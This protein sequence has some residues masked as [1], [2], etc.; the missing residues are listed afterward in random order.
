MAYTS[1][2]MA[3]I[4]AESPTSRLARSLASGVILL[5][6]VEIAG[7]I[8]SVQDDISG[9]LL[10][11][12]FGTARGELHV[13]VLY[14]VSSPTRDD[15]KKKLNRTVCAVLEERLRELR[16]KAVLA[17]ADLN[18]VASG[19]DRAGKEMLTYDMDPAAVWKVFEAGGLQDLHRLRHPNASDLS[20]VRRSQGVSRIDGIWASME[21]IR[22]DPGGVPSIRS[23]ITK[24]VLPLSVD[25]RTIQA[26]IGLP[27]DFKWQAVAGAGV[28]AVT[29]AP[30]PAHAPMTDKDVSEYR[31]RL[32][33]HDETI[34]EADV[35]LKRA[36]GEWPEIST[37]IERLGLQDYITAADVSVALARAHSAEGDAE[38]ASAEKAAKTLLRLADPYDGTVSPARKHRTGQLYSSTWCSQSCESVCRS[39]G[40]VRKTTQQPRTWHFDS[41]GSRYAT[42]VAAVSSYSSSD[43]GGHQ[44]SSTSSINMRSLPTDRHA[45]RRRGTSVGTRHRVDRRRCER[46]AAPSRR[47]LR[48][49]HARRVVRQRSLGTA[50]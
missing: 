38:F 21:L 33:E 16:G 27:V 24:N 48:R 32:K 1:K 7:A 18:V 10:H 2:T 47:A 12:T 44:Q 29:A 26:S 15:I 40:A 20:F 3:F 42:G 41:G 35:Q 28:V 45:E 30:R 39:A 34:M 4:E 8:L 31:T 13:L 46:G 22:W 25:H 49:V 6:P 9:R 50:T 19:M 36:V 11:V 37:A 17:M 43:T 5:L 23:A 14:A